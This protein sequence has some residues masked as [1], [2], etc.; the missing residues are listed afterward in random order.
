MAAEPPARIQTARLVLR[1]PKVSDIPDIFE[2]A[3]DPEVT[4]LMDWRRLSEPGQVSD[5][6]ARSLAAWSEGT[7]YTWV[8][9]EARDDRVLGAIALRSR[10]ADSD[11]GYVLNRKAWG[12]GIALEA[13]RALVDWLAS[14]RPAHRI[15]ATCDLENHRSARVL[16]KVGLKRER[17]MAQH[18]I[19]PNISP[20]ARDSYLYSNG[21]PEATGR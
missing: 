1:L 4:L 6:L 10:D 14:A 2:Y 9:T 5:F 7:E 16:E 3:S 13:S 21:V 18:V 17:V 20:S 11:F 12:R 19:R 8:I 15:W